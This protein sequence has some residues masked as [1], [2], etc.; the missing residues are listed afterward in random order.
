MQFSLPVWDQIICL[1]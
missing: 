1:Y